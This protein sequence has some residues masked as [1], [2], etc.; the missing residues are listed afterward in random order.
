[1]LNAQ[2]E[3]NNIPVNAQAAAQTDKMLTSQINGAA[4]RFSFTNT[5]NEQVHVVYL[6][7]I[8]INKGLAPI[9]E[10]EEE[11]EEDGSSSEE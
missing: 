8:I 2:S 10:V 5:Q 4:K 6:I 1:M 9:A 7:I 3:L 11:E